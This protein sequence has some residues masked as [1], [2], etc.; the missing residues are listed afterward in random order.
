VTAVET[1]GDFCTSVPAWAVA[2]KTAI[3]IPRAI[4]ASCPFWLDHDFCLGA[5]VSEISVF[6]IELESS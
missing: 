1:T 3:T 5:A 2:V 4:L 6:G